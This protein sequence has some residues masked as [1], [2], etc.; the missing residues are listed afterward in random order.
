[1]IRT[2]ALLVV[3]GLTAAACSRPPAPAGSPAPAT[4]AASVKPL[5]EPLPDVIARVN[6]QPVP[7]RHARIIAERALAGQPPSAERRAAVYRDA[8]E[9]LIARELLLQEALS[10]GVAPEQAA[11]DRAYDQVRVQYKDEKEWATFLAGEGLDPQSF[12]SELRV[13]HTVEA[14]L[15]QEAERSPATVTDEEAQA[16]YKANPAQFDSG[17]QVRASHILLRVP[18]GADAVAKF[19][20]RS[21][22]EDALKR[23]RAGADFAKLAHELSQDPQSGPRGGELSVFGRG[24]MVAPFEA[25]AFSLKPGQVSPVVETPYGYHIIKVHER[26]PPRRPPFEEVKQSLKQQLATFK[27]QEALNRLL[28]GL[29]SK[30]KIETFL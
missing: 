3:A 22:M 14:L 18:A 5:P 12:R 21:K 7:L 25:A 19:A 9:R 4:P 16:F 20:V 15:K 2:R 17:D 24:Q 23:V 6:G 13:R 29:R 30:A 1:M 8:M 10:R 11:V 28:T 27:R 26:I